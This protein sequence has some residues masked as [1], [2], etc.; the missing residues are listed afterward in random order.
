MVANQVKEVLA[1]GE[2]LWDVLPNEKLLGGAPANFC[3]RL[4]SLGT[5]ARIV[6]RIGCDPLGDQLLAELE[7]RKLDLSL[8]QRDPSKNTGTV[9]VTLNQEGNPHFTIVEDVAFD[10]IEFSSEL[11]EASKS[12][13]LIYFGTLAQRCSKT[14][15][16]LYSVLQQAKQAI[17]F[18]DINLRKDCYD[19]DIVQSSLESADI[20]KLNS[21]EVTLV[22]S[23][24]GWPKYSAQEFVKAV[25]S[26]FDISTVL[27]S[28]GELGVYGA[29]KDG[30]EISLNGL[31][32]K[33]F[34]TI[35]AGDSFSAGF[36]HKLVQGASLKDACTFGNQMGAL[37][38]TKKGGMAVFSSS[39]IASFV[40]AST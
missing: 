34:D 12:A 35:G 40:S 33:V 15:N 39:E 25:I 36:V 9:E 31:K 16:T 7:S 1:V 2:L 19:K 4:S 27:V 20:L 29:S 38:A 26:K 14:R 28:L 6:S 23:M 22:S 32:I 5:S 24:F 18:L 30:Q 37:A 10:Y 11:I 21:S 17:K 3:H 8:V 13:Y